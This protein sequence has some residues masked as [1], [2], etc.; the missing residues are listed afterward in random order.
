MEYEEEAGE[1]TQEDNEL[2]ETLLREKMQKYEEKMM[3]ASLNRQIHLQQER[4]R[5]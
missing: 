5:I 3:R 1:Y 4:E 2:E